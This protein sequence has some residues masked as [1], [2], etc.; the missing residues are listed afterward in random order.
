MNS[1]GEIGIGGMVGIGFAVVLLVL[2]MTFFAKYNGAVRLR[3]LVSATQKANTS[4]FD[5]MWKKIRDAA[6]VPDKQKDMLKDI[7]NSYATARSGKNDND[8]LLANWI[9]E[10]VP[11]VDQTTLLNL[12]N[13]ITG[14]R[15]AFAERQRLLVDQNREYQN[16]LTTI[17]W[18]PVLRGMGF[19][20][21]EITVI[22]STHADEEFATGKDDGEAF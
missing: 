3:N 12:Q 14:S 11:A 17:P 13:I 18:G 22:T 15:D 2:V 20:A 10:S 9:Q 1:S 6:K 4:D 5:A 19:R 21:L 7:F 16:C 8:K